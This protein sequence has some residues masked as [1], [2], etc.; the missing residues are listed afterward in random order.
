MRPIG[1]GAS[2]MFS[3]GAPS[4]LGES[5]PLALAI[6]SEVGLAAGLKIEAI[7]FHSNMTLRSTSYPKRVFYAKV[8]RACSV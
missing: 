1:V 2:N 5:A 3:S 4:F 6:R 7:C 8:L